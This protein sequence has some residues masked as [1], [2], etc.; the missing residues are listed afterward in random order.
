MRFWLAL[1]LSLLAVSGSRADVRVVP[2]SFSSARL[3]LKSL[4]ATVEIKNGFART[5]STWTFSNFSDADFEAETTVEAPR[6]AVVSAFAYWFRG[7]K[8]IARVVE[9]E[10]AERIY[11]E[12]TRGSRKRDPA[13]VE[14][15]SRHFFRAHIAPV[16]AHQDLKIEVVWME[17]L[18]R[19]SKEQT[20]D[21][22]LSPT[23]GT[24]VASW[25]VRV[26]G[27][28][29]TTN[30]GELQNGAIAG[31][32]QK[33]LP[34]FLRLSLPLG[35]TP[36]PLVWSRSGFFATTGSVP[37][38]ARDVFRSNRG[39][40]TV[41]IGKSNA[42]RSA[43]S[44][45]GEVAAT[46]WAA[47]KLDSL[48]GSE[49]NRDAAIKLSVQSGLLCGWTRWLAI[50]D[51]ERKRLEQAHAREMAQQK[52]GKL[53]PQLA[54]LLANGRD[55]SARFMALKSEFETQAKIVDGTYESL[56]PGYAQNEIEVLA[57]L[58][59]ETNQNDQPL[60]QRDIEARDA[61]IL[62]QLQRLQPFI[63][64]GSAQQSVVR[65]RRWV[66][67]RRLAPRVVR[68][69]SEFEAGRNDVPLEAEIA[70][71]VATEAD[72]G[73]DVSA[74][75]IEQNVLL[76][77]A[78]SW[79]KAPSGSAQQSRLEAK[80]AQLSRLA[81]APVQEA[82]RIR[83]LARAETEVSAPDSIRLTGELAGEVI[84]HR[85]D[86]DK[87]R[88][89]R[90]QL[91]ARRSQLRFATQ[92][93]MGGANL[94][95]A[96]VL[97]VGGA[98]GELEKQILRE[99]L[100][101]A[102]DTA[103]IASWASEVERLRKYGPPSYDLQTLKNDLAR[104]AEQGLTHEWLSLT[105]QPNF[106]RE[107]EQNVV[108]RYER[109]L[110][111]ARQENLSL[112]SVPGNAKTR[113]G[114][115][116]R[117]R[118]WAKIYPLLDTLQTQQSQLVP[119]EAALALT[120]G[121]LKAVVAA[122]VYYDLD[123]QDWSNGGVSRKATVEEVLN[124]RKGSVSENL[125]ELLRREVAKPA[126]DAATIEQ[127]QRR[128]EELAPF[129]WFYAQWKTRRTST[130]QE[131]QRER[132]ELIQALAALDKARRAKAPE[133]QV[134][135]L[136]QRENQLRVRVGDPLIAVKAPQ[137]TR[138]IVAVLPSGEPLPLAFNLETKQWE[139][140]FDVP[141]FQSEG[142]FDIQIFLVFA[143]G[144]RSHLMMR[145]NVD[146]SSPSGVAALKFD[147]QNPRLQLDCDSQT[148]RV[149]AF[150]D[151]GQRIELGRES[152]GRWSAP[153]PTGVQVGQK[154]RFV[155]TDAAHNRT[156]IALDL[157]EAQ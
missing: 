11:R 120:T 24:R 2:A 106:N 61:D 97:P 27:A 95:L 53:G 145:L 154:V 144:Q 98:Q 72:E 91:A 142:R 33:P 79:A 156:E 149:S 117:E 155:L 62:K 118:V 80:I 151:S 41:L 4:D 37:R 90:A 99:R 59:F 46:L 52:L 12:L 121:Q 73:S 65:A 109:L 134:A 55:K 108:A 141:A 132:I 40:Q 143:N 35:E 16:A 64:N 127:L 36:M 152:N 17:P 71:I 94:F 38:G 148:D 51:S 48:E 69:Q 3:Q 75:I 47:A 111:E 23:P 113:L 56:F 5:R 128:I 89:L 124:L 74:E 136:K 140:R 54:V 57:G 28:N 110:D 130:P 133:A 135:Q 30:V 25:K 31:D 18:T 96:D 101:L 112:N 10:R 20:L 7:Q 103:R 77:F 39:G 44:D 60:A 8:V 100:R 42:V 83:V 63:T 114:F 43:A 93:T 87:A 32:E 104:E 1:C 26:V 119:D 45:F 76:P 34:S 126:P 50:P 22:P 153:L 102:P 147:S 58:V 66:A 19:G 116:E 14:M 68:L 139:A 137:N 49:R 67:Q 81:P 82:A 13:L 86:G 21:F 105:A 150:F 6:D 125:L 9:R 15:L 115:V 85:E 138:K 146:L 84:A 29:P 70:R 92:D 131:F 157:S 129:D 78:Q 107:Q 123:F 88:E 122:S